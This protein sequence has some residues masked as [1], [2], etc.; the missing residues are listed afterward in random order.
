MNQEQPERDSEK[1]NNFEERIME[2]VSNWRKLI[3][4]SFKEEEEK[5]MEVK[6]YLKKLKK[7]C[8]REGMIKRKSRLK[9][10]VTKRRAA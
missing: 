4:D 7:N 1:K 8:L 2:K 10:E 6:K 3:K 9:E 5:V